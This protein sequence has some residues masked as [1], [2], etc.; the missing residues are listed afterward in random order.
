MP[1]E[2][3]LNPSAEL[4]GGVSKLP[5]LVSVVDV[6]GIGCE[7]AVEY[8]GMCEYLVCRLERGG[9][10]SSNCGKVCAFGLR[11]VKLEGSGM[12]LIE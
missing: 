6:V 5:T 2:I 4:L 9:G 3:G 1:P 8:E 10:G 7:D 12:V 11:A